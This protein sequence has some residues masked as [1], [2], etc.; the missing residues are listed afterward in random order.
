MGLRM[1][2]AFEPSKHGEVLIS[3]MRQYLRDIQGPDATLPS[4]LERSLPTEIAARPN[5]VTVLAFVDDVP[6][7]FC[8][9]IDSFSTFACKPVLNIHDMFAAP[10]F[11]GQGIGDALLEAMET[12][13]RGKGCCKLT[14]EVLEHNRRALKLYGRFGFVPH[15]QDPAL[16]KAL[17][18][19]KKL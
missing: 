1:E 12:I 8:I 17:F 2:T 3:L 4:V 7:G 19:E 10:A 14:L 15:T 18:F 16:G 9:G 5:I 6:A 11:R 13:A